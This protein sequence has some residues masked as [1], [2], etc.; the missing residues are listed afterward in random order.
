MG[1]LFVGVAVYVAVSADD[2][3]EPLLMAAVL[4]IGGLGL[5][6]VV[7]ALRNKESLLARIGPLP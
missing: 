5:D 2:P 7:A 6:A 3:A 4:L 1:M